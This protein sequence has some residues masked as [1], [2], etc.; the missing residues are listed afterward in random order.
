[1]VIATHAAVTDVDNPLVQGG[2]RTEMVFKLSFRGGK[3]GGREIAGMDPRASA[4]QR[5]RTERGRAP[6][7]GWPVAKSTGRTK[8]LGTLFDQSSSLACAI[9]HQRLEVQPR[10]DT[11]YT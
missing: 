4:S 1:M 11:E 5:A 10:P 3:V 7:R 2:E 8:C 6:H 9:G